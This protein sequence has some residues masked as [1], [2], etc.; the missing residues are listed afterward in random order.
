MDALAA[1]LA[2]VKK[3]GLAQGQLLGFLHVLI[4]RRISSEGT[5]ISAGLAWRDLASWLKKMRWEPEQARELGLDPDALP[6][7]DRQRFW[8]AVITRAGVDSAAAREA[9]DRFA[10]TLQSQ[11][12]EVGPAPS[13]FGS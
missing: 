3:L 13:G 12:Y 2:Q 5:L 6:P 10:A 8:Y 4:G 11:G 9:G 1:F 7:R